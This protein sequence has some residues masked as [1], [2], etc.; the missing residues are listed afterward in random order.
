MS[1][2]ATNTDFETSLEQL[3]ALVT[4]MEK[5]QLSLDQSLEAFEEGIK[6]TRT[7]QEKL[8]NAEQRVNKLVSEGEQ[9]QLTPFDESEQ[10]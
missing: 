9:I 7:C 1:E 4:K 8:K 3:E 5:G 10:D 2:Q 6:L